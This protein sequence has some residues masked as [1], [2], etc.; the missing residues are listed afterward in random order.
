MEP[1]QNEKD[2]SPL[3]F[4]FFKINFSPYKDVQN[5]KS[6]N[7]LSDVITFLSQEQLK[8]KGLLV[9]KHEGRQKDARR[10]L[11]VT[12]V[13][14]MLKEKRIVGSIALLRTGK[15]PLLKPAEKFTLIPLDT[16]MGEVAEQTHF[17]IDYSTDET[18][19][20]V[21]YNH[22]GPRFSDIEFYFRIVARD[23]LKL[24]KA[25]EIEM[26]MDISI[27]KVLSELRNV[28]NLDVKLQPQKLAQ[29][30][31]GLKGQYFSGI[32]TLGNLVNPK[33][34][35]LE[36]MFQTQ[37][38]QYASS[39]INR[40][41]NNMV[42]SFLQLF[43]EK[44]TNMDVFDNFVIKYEGKDGQED[45]FNLV[46]GKK[47]IVKYADVRQLKGRQWYELIEEDLTEFVQSLPK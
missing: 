8:G 25:T 2:L 3:K 20:C 24:A 34:I 19:L 27:D 38:R 18:V 43:K 44:P 9:D 7:I 4:H 41:A 36:A 46:K 16:S 5:K 47:E 40:N 12:S 32:S 31:N 35:K 28:L 15:I 13:Y 23:K 33:F 45:V 17:F 10:P 1:I 42:K 29:L 6:Q 39:E 26:F 37:G 30:D 21:E 22:E 11:F 14:F